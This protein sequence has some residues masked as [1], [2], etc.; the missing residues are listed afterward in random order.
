MKWIST[1]L[2][3]L[4]AVPGLADSL[5]YRVLIAGEDTGHLKVE[6]DGSKIDIDF[7]YK[8]NGRGPTIT[9]ALT[10]DDRGYP[11]DWTISGTTTFGS[12]VDEYFRANDG[13]A[14]WR[15]ATGPGDS[16][17]VE[18]TAFYIDQNGSSYAS[19]LLV[20]ALLADPDQRLTVFP[21][22]EASLVKQGTRTLA[23]GKGTPT[24]TVTAY[25]IL[26]LDTAPRLVLLDQDNNYFGT[27]SARFALVPKGFE[28]AEKQL[29]GW[30]EELSTE[31]F[32]SIQAR[33]A[34]RFDHPVR[35]R[36]VRLFDPQ[37]LKLTQEKDVVIYGN[38]VSSVQPAGYPS[39]GE[40]VT[41]DGEGGTLIPGMYEMHGHLG[42]GNALLN[43]VAGVTSVRDMGNEN[44]VLEDLMTRI[45]SG[46]IAGP[47]ITRSCFIEGDSEFASATGE[48]VSSLDGALEMVRWCGARDFHQIK[49]YNSMRPEWAAELTEEAH[50]LGMRVAGHVPAFSSANAMIAA[51]F[52][53]ITHANQLMLGWVL[54]PDEDTRTLFRFT[55]M[56]RF[57]Q[58]GVD[59]PRVRETIDAM[60]AG[61]V[62]HDPTIAIHEHGLTAIN[63]EPAPMAQAIIDHLP[64][65]EQRALK[66][67]LFGTDS[68]AERAEYIAAFGFITEVLAELHESG[69]LLVPGTD[70]GGSF[71]YHRELELFAT[72]GMTPAEVLRRAGW[73]MAEYLGQIE[74]LGSIEKGKYAD[75]FLVPGDPT[76]DLGELRKIRMVSSNGVLYFP[77]EVYPEFGIRPFASAPKLM[78]P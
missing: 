31:R 6:R 21:G 48:T 35:I 20:K 5:E 13:V 58:L 73:D 10:I 30:A 40:E 44:A 75:F 23:G 24:A 50:R 61:G 57:P 9:E 18:Q 59:D 14:R 8:Q 16:E 26:G 74:D 7:D 43:V 63:G 2:I 1:L 66:R 34:H 29:R 49:L 12:P 72:L 15:D 67:E 27:A 55:A 11:T 36:N 51:G 78:T 68:P 28:S 38:R 32:V 39:A 3:T 4:L 25:E 19:S 62:S 41:V 76:A 53:E 22:G 69:V 65:N 60:V 46:L 47:R 33:V 37:S 54:E 45:N 77:E 70:L 42:Q 17:F 64:T 71:F 52:D 56:R